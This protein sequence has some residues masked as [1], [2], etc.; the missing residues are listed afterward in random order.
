[1]EIS[2]YDGYTACIKV[3]QLTGRLCLR[4]FVGLSE[5]QAKSLDDKLN[6]LSDGSLKH[7]VTTLY[8]KVCLFHWR[9]LRISLMFSY[10]LC[11]M[12]TSKSR[13]LLDMSPAKL[14]MGLRAKL[15]FLL[16]NMCCT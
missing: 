10:S 5:A 1:V 3:D 12:P 8:S 14:P 6:D 9:S 16:V 11:C 13:A 7:V 4:D 15:W 2:L